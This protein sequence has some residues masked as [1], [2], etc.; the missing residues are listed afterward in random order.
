MDF[1]K[2][3]FVSFFALIAIDYESGEE[4]ILRADASL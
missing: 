4:I 3:K 2:L 1:L